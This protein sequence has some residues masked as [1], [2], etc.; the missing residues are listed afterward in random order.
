MNQ[1]L[2]DTVRKVIPISK[3]DIDLTL[4][5]FRP[6]KFKRNEVLLQDGNIASEVFF[7]CKGVVHQFYI[8]ET[9]NERTCDFTFENQ[10]STDLESFSQKKP[11]TSSIKA[12]KETVC[13]V[14]SC[15]DLMRLTE[16]SVPVKYYF[17]SV[18]E[19]IAAES[20]RR[21][22]S[23]LTNSP[24]K[25]FA[26]LLEENPDI[27]QKVPQRYI[28]QYLGIAPESLSRIKKRKMGAAKS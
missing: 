24:E 27:F 18:V 19:G 28:A 5:F 21:T 23:L 8:D 1:A 4:S 26:E 12:L 6:K 17:N 14:I 16:K 9:G 25:R 3:E 10:F 2:I 20:M 22:R 13:L 11:A 15:A 7:V